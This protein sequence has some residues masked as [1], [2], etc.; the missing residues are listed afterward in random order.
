MTQFMQYPAAQRLKQLASQ[1]FDLTKSNNLTPERLADFSAEAC[2]YKL[3]Y[4]TERVTKEV[5]QTLFSLSKE[6]HVFQKM[7]AMQSGATINAI[8]GFPS[9]NRSVLHT[10]TRD[11]FD[12]QNQAPAAR[13][14]AKQSLLQVEKLRTFMAKI[15]REQ[16]FT[17]V[18]MIG[19]GGSDLGPRAHY[20]SLQHLLKPGRRAHFIA[21][22][23]PDDSSAVFRDLDLSKTLVLVVSKTGTTMETA[24][25]EAFMRKK[26]LE[27]KLKPEE[28]IVSI[29]MPGSPLDDPKKY[30]ACFHMWDWVG[31]RYS[32]T[33]MVGGVLL[34]FAFGVEVFWEFL[35]GASAMDKI[36]LKNKPETNLPLLAALLGI[37]NRNFLEH[38]ML[39]II[40]Y[41]QALLRYPAHIQQLDMES[42]GK[43][44]DKSGQAVAFETGPII[45]GE[46]GTSSQHSFFQL[47]HQGTTVV[48]LEF[49][50][51]KESQ[52]GQDHLIDGTTSQQK[53][54]SNL[55]AQILALATGQQSDNPNKIFPGNRP[56]HLLLGKQL[57]PF[58]LGA[59]LAFYEHKVAFQGFI[60]NINSFDQEGVQLG[61]VLATKIIG[62]FASPSS[63]AYPLADALLKKLET[64][65]E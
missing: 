37:W 50:G 17:D 62:R 56:S 57:T 19:I 30:L 2:G 28:H 51:F 52:F 42:D 46:V 63:P 29:T 24:T 55:F 14:A 34:A 64:F 47:L 16:K 44:I 61:K 36:S 13:E 49:I 22:I 8:E 38:P 7:E 58:A 33:S 53:L 11:F 40:P 12:D 41:S 10:A 1:P 31:G 6:A 54:L 27:A 43:R 45:W 20:L 65:N 32:T 9:E 59:L 4:G 39:A 25:N 60:W 5:M 48:P 23:D 18:V 3:L 15:D 35:R 21:N 26:L